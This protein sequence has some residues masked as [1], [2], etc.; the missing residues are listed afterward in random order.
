MHPTLN[1]KYCIILTPVPRITIINPSYG[2]N[3]SFLR[4]NF[5]CKRDLNDII[6]QEKK[7]VAYTFL[8][9]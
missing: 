3:L 1:K 4:H 5:I 2:P 8:H 9:I 7:R 6:H